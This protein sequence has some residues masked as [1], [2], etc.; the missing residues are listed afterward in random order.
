[1][2]S[3][4]DDKLINFRDLIGGPLIA[5]IEADFTASQRFVEYMLEYGMEKLSDENVPDIAIDPQTNKP[6][7]RLKMVTFWYTQANPK[8]G[9]N[10][11][12]RVEVPLLSLIPLPLL[13]IQQA[14]FDFNIRLFSEIEYKSEPA[15]QK[16]ALENGVKSV[17]EKATKSEIGELKGFK[18]RLSPSTGRSEDGKISTS[19]DANMKVT[20]KMKQADLPVG[21][22]SLMTV[23]NST[24]FVTQHSLKIAESETTSLEASPGEGTTNAG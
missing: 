20:V 17:E 15:G 12:F 13:Q 21:L 14:D 23:F 10:D 19:L 22:A 3:V 18:A 16:G 2:S 7:G 9:G 4:E 6:F 1:M 8:T 5:T 11:Y 24:T